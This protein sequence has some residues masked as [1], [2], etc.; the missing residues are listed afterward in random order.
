[1]WTCG[2]PIRSLAG[3]AGFA[4]AVAVNGAVLLPKEPSKH[5]D[6]K[7]AALMEDCPELPSL[8]QVTT[9]IIWNDSGFLDRD[10]IMT[11]FTVNST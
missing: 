6:K 10:W 8:N 9:M 3:E 5:L 4:C 1:L 2:L 7:N 11:S